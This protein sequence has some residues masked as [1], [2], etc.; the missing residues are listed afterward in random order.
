MVSFGPIV[1]NPYFDKIHMEVLKKHNFI[2]FKH[3][4]D[5]ECAKDLGI[6][7]P[8]ITFFRKYEPQIVSY[9]GEADL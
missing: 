4:D 1:D 3:N 9:T 6:E 8:S 5:E 7:F 2:N